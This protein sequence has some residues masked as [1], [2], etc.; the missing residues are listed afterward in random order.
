MGLF[1]ICE[2]PGNCLEEVHAR[3][4]CNKHYRAMKGTGAFGATCFEVRCERGVV[5][6]GR[7]AHHYYL[8]RKNGSIPDSEGEKRTTCFQGTCGGTVRAKQRCS[9][10]YQ[11]YLRATKKEETL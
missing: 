10:H 5:S 3:G 4:F 8:A 1:D 9:K 11:Q 6:K 7:C 2:Y